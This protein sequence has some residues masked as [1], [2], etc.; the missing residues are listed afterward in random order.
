MVHHRR[1]CCPEGFLS[2]SR[3][4]PKSHLSDCAAR[5]ESLELRSPPKQRSQQLH[6]THKVP[7]L[8][9]STLRETDAADSIANNCH[10]SP[11]CIRD[12][13]FQDHPWGYVLWRVVKSCVFLVKKKV[14]FVLTKKCQHH[15]QHFVTF[16]AVFIF[17]IECGPRNK[18]PQLSC[19]S[20]LLRRSQQA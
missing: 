19:C 14:N 8:A 1:G 3:T 6:F 20:G 16:L 10:V 15:H 11:A 17:T 9:E 13:G 4:Q 12:R 5:A 2:Q 7:S 18:K